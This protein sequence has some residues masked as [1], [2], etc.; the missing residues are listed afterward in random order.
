MCLPPDSDHDVLSRCHRLRCPNGQ[1]QNLA[2][3]AQ[4]GIA[5]SNPVG[6]P[7]V[8]AGQTDA[9]LFGKIG[10]RQ[11][12]LDPG[13]TKVAAEVRFTSQC[14]LL[15]SVVEGRHLVAGCVYGKPTHRV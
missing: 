3:C 4:V 13:I 2:E 12:T 7:E 11:A 15:S 1:F 8:N 6:L 5:R 10:Y 9:D 14:N